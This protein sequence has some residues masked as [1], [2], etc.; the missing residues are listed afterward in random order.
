MTLVDIAYTLFLFGVIALF[1]V[2][3]YITL[4]EQSK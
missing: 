1:S 2:L 4:Q 3:I